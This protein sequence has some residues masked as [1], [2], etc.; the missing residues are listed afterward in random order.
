MR[1]R[2]TLLLVECSTAFS[3]QY[4]P[5]RTT[6]NRKFERPVSNEAKRAA[7]MT[8]SWPLR[9]RPLAFVFGGNG[10]CTAVPTQKKSPL[11]IA[12]GDL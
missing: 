5:F 8:Q 4:R 9:P 12:S 7:L 3:Q 2:Q 6:F 11:V 1:Q 10:L